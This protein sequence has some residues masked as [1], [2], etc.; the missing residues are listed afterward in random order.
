MIMKGNEGIAKLI[1]QGN[2]NVVK[3]ITAPKSVTTPDGR[4]YTSQTRSVN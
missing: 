1:A 2:D 3:A 4:T